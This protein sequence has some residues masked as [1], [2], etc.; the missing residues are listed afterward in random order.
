MTCRRRHQRFLLRV[1]LQGSLRFATDVLF[2]RYD[3]QEM[4]VLSPLPAERNELLRIN[5]V[6]L[7]PPLGLGMRVE[8]SL[9]VIVDGAVQHRLRLRTAP[10]ASDVHR[11][12][13]MVT[14]GHDM[15]VR[16]LNISH[17]GC[18]V[19]GDEPVDLAALGELMLVV[20]GRVSSGLVRVSRSLAVPGRGAARRIGVQFVGRGSCGGS[21]PLAVGRLAEEEEWKASPPVGR[22]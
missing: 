12:D 15:P 18:L 1:P 10:A 4:Q 5:D 6:G 21:L 22:K 8:E 14:L 13:L 17:G 3:G 19:E 20:G 16:V 11:A 9:P 2:E 7:R